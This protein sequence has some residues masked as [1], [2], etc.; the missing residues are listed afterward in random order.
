MAGAAD[1][2][3]SETASG[4]VVNGSETVPTKYLTWEAG[5]RVSAENKVSLESNVYYSIVRDAI[6]ASDDIIFDYDDQVLESPTREGVYA[7]YYLYGNYIKGTTYGVETVFKIIPAKGT[8]IELSHVFTESKWEYQE[9]DD[10]KISEESGFDQDKIDRTPSTPKI[11]KHVLRV[12]GTFDLPKNF[13]FSTSVLYASKFGTESSYDF[14]QQRHPN[15]LTRSTG[16]IVATN[17]SR[18]IFSLRLER[19]FLDE[20]LN[21]YLFGN[22]IFNEGI[23][24]NT[25]ALS[26]VTLSKVGGMFGLG[27]NYK[28]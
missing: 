25:T 10:F 28:F 14:E 12:K 24:G 22:D 2:L 5:F 8:V 20:N 6:S 9:N 13:K 23:V 17:N 18:T 26:N 1:A 16:Q 19:N 7:D 3:R 27:A 11:P 4:G 21:V 15:I